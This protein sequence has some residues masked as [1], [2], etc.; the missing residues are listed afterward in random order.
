MKVYLK[1]NI[2]ILLVAGWYCGSAFSVFSAEV[3][4]LEKVEDQ[5]TVLGGIRKFEVAHVDE[6]VS[7]G[8]V[9]PTTVITFGTFDLFHIGHLRIL[10]RAKTQGDRLVVG[11][12]SD[13]FSFSKKGKATFKSEVQ[14]LLNFVE[15]PQVA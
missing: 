8:I 12:S 13:A 3:Q 5:S 7:K 6:A 1:K 11:I 4:E 10:Q 9:Q 15:T 2:L 14:H